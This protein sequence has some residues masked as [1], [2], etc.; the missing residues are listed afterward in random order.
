[1]QYS[2]L[3]NI[4][5]PNKLAPFIVIR[6]QQYSADKKTEQDQSCQVTTGQSSCS[7]DTLLEMILY[8]TE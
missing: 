3:L 7:E 4:N 5:I 6:V 8:E 2:V 1:M